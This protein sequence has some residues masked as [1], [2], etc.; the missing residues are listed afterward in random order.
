MDDLPT[1][2]R[3]AYRHGNWDIFPGQYFKEW[4]RSVHVADLTIPPGVDRLRGLDWGYLRPGVCLWVAC[5]PDGRLYVEDEYVFTETIAQDVAREIAARTNARGVKV[6]Y[7]S[8]DPAMWIRDG[9]SGESIAETFA[10]ER[11]PLQAAN[12]ERVNGWQRVRH[13]LRLAPD[14]LPWL[15]VSPRCAY[16]SRTMPGLM[17]DHAKPEDVNTDGEDHAADALRYLLMSRPAPTQA[18]GRREYP[19]DSAGALFQAAQR[20]TRTVLGSENVVVH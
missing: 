18:L 11:V 8:A 12:H 2:L 16:L 6:R 4:R 19:E 9:Q 3:D 7:T 13:W 20:P 15:M 17:T 1:E 10:R 14:G 5:L